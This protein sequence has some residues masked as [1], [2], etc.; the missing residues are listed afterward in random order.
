MERHRDKVTV[1]LLLLP[2][3]RARRAPKRVMK[4]KSILLVF[5]LVLATC[6]ISI[7]TLQADDGVEG[8]DIVGTESVNQDVMMTATAAAPVSAAM[9]LSV[10]A[11]DTNGAT[12]ATLKVEGGG[13]F[14]GTNSVS[15]TLKSD[16]SSVVLGSF[17]VT[18]EGEAEAEF[19]GEGIAFPAN[20]NAFDIATV[21][22]T[23]SNAVV[24]FTANLGQLSSGSAST[25]TATV[26]AVPGSS[27]PNAAGTAVLN[28]VLS[29][30]QAKGS[31]Q[32]IGH[33]L[34]ANAVL[35]VT[36][37]GIV[38]NVKKVNTDKRGNVSVNIGP[39]GKTSTV[40]TGVTLFQ[41]TSM[42]L[43]DRFGNTLLGAAF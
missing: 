34:P 19:G 17:I 21:S 5:P 24:L 10:E 40:A 2:G 4:I 8:G 41:V 43:S 33:G 28:A 14:A 36:V 11:E 15:V 18:T 32:L 7:A 1:A 9:E 6:A 26:Q 20:F 3:F 31:L 23:D 37:N 16:G 39:K 30:G 12:T 38:S 42:R 27:D 25:R 13:L 22:V 29:G 35:T